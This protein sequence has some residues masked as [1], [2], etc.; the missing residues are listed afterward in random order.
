MSIEDE[1]AGFT[2][3][4]HVKQGSVAPLLDDIFLSFNI[5]YYIFNSVKSKLIFFKK[6]ATPLM[7]VAA[8]SKMV[9]NQR[10]I[11][12]ITV[13]QQ[14]DK[15]VFE[16]YCDDEPLLERFYSEKMEGIRVL[17]EKLK[18]ENKSIIIKYID[19]VK[20]LDIALYN[21]LHKTAIR[22]I[23]LPVANA[24]E[25]LYKIFSAEKFD[26]LLISMGS[27]LE[28]LRKYSDEQ[29]LISEDAQKY[30]LNFLNWKTDLLEKIHNIIGR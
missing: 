16:L 28:S 7:E 20:L 2:R 25:I 15:V 30:A 26:P 8:L 23:Y 14:N 21:L 3:G 9:E 18:A 10:V 22:E 11:V 24:R 19:V 1:L 17:S 6:T 5:L 12:K 4:M 13:G 29:S 27:L